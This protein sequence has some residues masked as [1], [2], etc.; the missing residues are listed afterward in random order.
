MLDPTCPVNWKHPLNQ[1]R[2]C[3]WY[4][5]W[6]GGH[7]GGS[8]AGR[9]L[10]NRNNLSFTSGGTTPGWTITPRQ[11][12]AFSFGGTGGGNGWYAQA[13]DSTATLAALTNNFT[14]GCTF[15]TDTITPI[16][17][18]G[19][20]GLMGTYHQ[21]SDNSWFLRQDD[22]KLE[23]G[24]GTSFLSGNVLDTTT[25]F[26]VICVCQDGN[27]A[28][29]LN[30]DPTPIATGTP[31]YSA[32]TSP[33]RIGV[34]FL[35]SARYFIGWIADAFVSVRPWTTGDVA[36]DYKLSKRNYIENDSPLNLLPILRN[37]SGT[38]AEVV[39]F[40]TTLGAGPTM[41][42]ANP[43]EFE[44]N[45]VASASAGGIGPI[46][47]EGPAEFETTVDVLP[48]FGGGEPTLVGYETTVGVEDEAALGN[49]AEFTTSVGVQHR[50]VTI[51][52]GNRRIVSQRRYR[53]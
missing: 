27:S 25:I 51:P 49:P 14:F 18:N 53:R 20:A 44:T 43:G 10:C 42:F 32:S 19:L 30:G 6:Q 46:N 41:T 21:A 26:R 35:A 39:N 13:I 8:A 11:M 48:I 50:L 37:G 28:I 40:T 52:N 33:A 45:L 7:W 31:A 9:D 12:P 23:M 15:R 36:L 34:D 4:G 5:A 24:G 38:A 2:R 22:A 29:Y 1:G 17:I 3:W 47:P 16:D